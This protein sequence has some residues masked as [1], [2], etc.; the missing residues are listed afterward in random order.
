[1]N[2]LTYM[3]IVVYGGS[4]TNIPNIADVFII[5][6]T[7]FL[8]LGLLGLCGTMLCSVFDKD[9]NILLKVTGVLISISMLLLVVSILCC[10]LGV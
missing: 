2:L 10:I 8:A 4:S 9:D 3:L 1:M 6:A 7:G 5:G